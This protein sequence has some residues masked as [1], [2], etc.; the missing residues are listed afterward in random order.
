MGCRL[1]HAK[2]YKVDWDTA[3]SG[4]FNWKAA[5][6]QS[7]LRDFKVDAWFSQAEDEYGDMEI[8]KPELRR[9]VKLLQSEDPDRI[10]NKDYE[11]EEG[12]ID[13][14][15]VLKWARNAL[16]YSDPDID[17]VRFTWF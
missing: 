10:L 5:S 15:T 2:T 6:L 14:G 1:Y 3:H 4:Y 7:I 8:T 17:Y 16:T 12:P 13:A 11:A 9:L